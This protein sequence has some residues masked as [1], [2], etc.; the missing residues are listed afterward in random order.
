MDKNKETCHSSSDDEGKHQQTSSSR[1]D[2][3]INKNETG[4]TVMMVGI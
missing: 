4:C 1:S 2:D 3:G